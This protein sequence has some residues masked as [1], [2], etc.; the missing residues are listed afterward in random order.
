MLKDSKYKG[1]WY[2]HKYNEDLPEHSSEEHSEHSLE[3]HSEHSSEEHSEH[4]SEEHSEHSSEE[5][6]EHSSAGEASKCRYSNYDTATL[7]EHQTL[8][9]IISIIILF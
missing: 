5:H 4:S 3:E 9:I 8:L 7:A 6:S 2:I 1:D